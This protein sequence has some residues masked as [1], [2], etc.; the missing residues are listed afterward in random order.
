MRCDGNNFNF[1]EN[2]LTKLANL[3]QFIRMLVFSPRN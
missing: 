2:A 1:F 3:V